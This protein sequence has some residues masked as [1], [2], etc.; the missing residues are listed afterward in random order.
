MKKLCLYIFII[1]ITFSSCIE[2]LR[3]ISTHVETGK[4]DG[5]IGYHYRIYFENKTD[6]TIMISY[7]DGR[8]LGNIR[9]GKVKIFN[10]AKQSAVDMVGK[11]SHKK[12]FSIICSFD[13][14]T[15]VIE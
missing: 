15:V 10:V 1:L 14:M 12:Y 13:L 11:K 8:K 3:V 4:E 5:T 2:F 9:K 6:E 7:Y